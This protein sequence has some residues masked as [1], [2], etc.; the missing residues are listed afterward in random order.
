MN[1]KKK[2]VA[3]SLVSLAVDNLKF[4]SSNRLGRAAP[5][6]Q[7]F[8]RTIHLFFHLI[9]TTDC[10]RVTQKIIVSMAAAG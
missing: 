4:A 10:A 6:A 8:S 3:R 2:C 5:K 9:K 7:R 1:K